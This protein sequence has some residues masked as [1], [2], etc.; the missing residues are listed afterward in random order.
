[1]ASP[2]PK[3]LY[4]TVKASRIPPLPTPHWGSQRS[5][6]F[7]VRA[8]TTINASPDLVLS[9]LL[10]TSSWPRW[11][12]FVPRATLKLPISASDS[13]RLRAGVVFTEH[14]DM[15]GK[16]KNTIVKM[17]L[18]MTSLDDL[19]EDDGRKGFR[20]VWLGKGY[21]DWALRSERVHEI[22]RNE[23]GET[24][25]DVYET[26]SGPL[27]WAVRVFVGE[28]LVKRFAQWDGELKEYVEGM[29]GGKG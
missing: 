2:P 27:G 18:L 12:N 22:F 26:F 16:G 17:K 20:V 5:P 8:T 21:P 9:T 25:Y 15:R 29:D 11:N 24:I 7:T 23:E 4:D 14:V 13:G 28:T 6:A 1:M 3:Q 19:N 10:D